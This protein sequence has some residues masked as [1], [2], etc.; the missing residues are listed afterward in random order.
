MKELIMRAWLPRS[1][2]DYWKKPF[3]LLCF[4]L[5][6]L[7]STEVIKSQKEMSITLPDKFNVSSQS[8]ITFNQEQYLG[9]IDALAAANAGK[10]LI[11]ENK[12]DAPK[13]VKK[14]KRKHKKRWRP[15]GYY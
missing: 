8:N 1:E 3:L 2:R 6:L 15:A 13:P 7:L 14:V 10:T 4:S 12:I 9:L 11:I 5:V